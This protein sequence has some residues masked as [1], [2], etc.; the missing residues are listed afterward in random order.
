MNRL[1]GGGWSALTRNQKIGVIVVALLVI[2]GLAT[3]GGGLLGSLA[4]PGRLLAVLAIVFIALPVHE[5]AHAA[6][7][8]A[9]GDETPRQQGRYTLNPLVH[10]DPLGAILILLTGFGWAKPV[11]WQ[12]RNIDID[13]R[14]GSIIVSAAGPL[15]NL[16]LAGIASATFNALPL[17][18][19]FGSLAFFLYFFASIN[20]LLFVFNLIPVPPLDGSHILFA[21]LPGDTYR[22]HVQ[23]SQYGILILF[24]IIFFVPEVI[25]TPTRLIMAGIGM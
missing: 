6:A 13:P 9:L 25:R 23:L 2:Y 19:R 10:I 8:V 5:Y 21:L 20:I 4:N 11:M 18:L 17:E 24:G 15:S 14:I 3:A 22:L 1:R 12:P 7:A 16:I